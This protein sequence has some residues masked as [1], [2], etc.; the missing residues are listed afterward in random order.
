VSAG[1]GALALA[2]AA[3]ACAAALPAAGAAPPFRMRVL[4]L[5]DHSR[6]ATF[7][8][9]A[10][11]PRVLV[12]YVRVPTR[13]RPPY[14]LVVFAHG[15]ALTPQVYAPMLDTW[16]RAGYVVA[17]P[18]FPVE[19]A[20]AP[21]G[22]DQ[23][24]LV[25]EPGDLSFVLSQLTAPAG[26]LR[27]LADPR[28]IAFAG[29]SDGAITALEAAYDPRYLDRR[30]DAAMVLSGATFSG[31]PGPPPTAPPLLAVQGTADPLNSPDTTAA[32][33]RLM[34][35][36]K[37]LLWLLGATHLPPYT[38][39]DAWAAVVDRTTTAFLD[40]YLRGA[41]LRPLLAAGTRPGVA[42]I[43]PDG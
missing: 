17:A 34:R 39:R 19:N 27:G 18:V 31:F 43:V 20:D 42:R 1:R 36:P 22:P 29:Q 38:T 24:D 3:A 8:D 16:A 2:V 13:G 10:S 12:T 23:S 40:H 7:R 41:P 6:T 30:V 35:R 5:V 25:N 33:F 15:F 21:G 4:R 11:G 28:R 32:Y 26:P 14:P 37:F 9:G